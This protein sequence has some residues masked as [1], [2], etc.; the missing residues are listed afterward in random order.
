MWMLPKMCRFRL[1]LCRVH[2]VQ[3]F[4]HVTSWVCAIFMPQ[5]VWHGAVLLRKGVWY[6]FCLLE[7]VT[8]TF[9]LTTKGSVRELGQK[10]G[11]NAAYARP[12]PTHSNKSLQ[13]DRQ[14]DRQTD[15][16]THTGSGLY[17]AYVPSDI[18]L[19]PHPVSTHTH[20]HTHAHM[21]L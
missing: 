15:T 9:D 6:G 10:R 3:A 1:E 21:H 18:R 2:T 4:V 16:H 19:T 14:T 5:S 8:I 17:W 12:P 7:R 13:A 20:T 11:S